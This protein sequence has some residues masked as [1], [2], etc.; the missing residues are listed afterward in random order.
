MRTITDSVVGT[1]VRIDPSDTGEITINGIS[2]SL[3]NARTL[4]RVDLVSGDNRVFIAEHILSILG[5][6]GVTSAEVTGINTDWDYA[7]PEHRF[8]RSTENLTPENVVGHPKGLHDPVAEEGLREVK[9]VESGDEQRKTV[10]ESIEYGDSAIRIAPREKGEGLLLRNHNEGEVIS[11][12]VDP[13]SRSD[14]GNIKLI[15]TS[16]TPFLGG[17]SREGATHWVGDMVSD[18]GVIGGFDDLVIDSYTAGHDDTIGISRK[19]HKENK[20]VQR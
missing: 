7:R 9:I 18:I 16:T 11:F 19:A 12:T 10:T 6:H 3:E 5:M 8:A 17:T 15:S 4:F 14:I 13:L 1:E 2:A 20:T